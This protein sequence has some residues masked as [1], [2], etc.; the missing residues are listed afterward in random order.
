MP[1][2]KQRWLIVVDTNVFVRSFKARSQSNPNRRIIRAWLLEKRLQL[3]VSRELVEEYLAI[4]AE[5]LGMDSGLIA[6]WRQRFEQDTRVTVV[7]LARR[8]TESRDPDDNL[9]LATARAG[10]ARY[11]LTND[12][13][14]LDLP[15]AARRSFPFE[16]QTPQ[17]F[18]REWEAA[19]RRSD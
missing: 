1:I 3:V 16:I 18:L 14:L 2:R 8:Y 10:K 4:F 6:Q 13:D 12:R 17:Q 9:L 15:E 19:G 7:Q 11:L 5:V